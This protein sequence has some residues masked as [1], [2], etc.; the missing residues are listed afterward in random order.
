MMFLSKFEP[1]Q[2]KLVFSHHHE[3]PF[4]SQCLYFVPCVWVC[5]FMS[6]CVYVFVYRC[7]HFYNTFMYNNIAQHS[8][9]T[10]RIKEYGRYAAIEHWACCFCSGKGFLRTFIAYRPFS[11]RIW[12]NTKIKTQE[13]TKQ[14][15]KKQKFVFVYFCINRLIGFSL[16]LTLALS[17]SLFIS[18][19]LF[20]YRSLAYRLL[21]NISIVQRL[22][23]I[24]TSEMFTQN[25]L[26]NVW[27]N[28]ELR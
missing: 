21:R 6:L 4:S 23:Q 22:E 13:K 1:H 26:Q 7:I 5:V 14:N 10:Y 3:E 2:N 17:F 28:E 9:N 16:T 18:F 25:A 20:Y 15:K 27:Y 12:P 24:E 11:N 8:I 19:S